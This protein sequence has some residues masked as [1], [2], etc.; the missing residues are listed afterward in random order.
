MENVNGWAS[1][2]RNLSALRP[3]MVNCVEVAAIF[4]YLLSLYPGKHRPE[5]QRL[6]ENQIRSLS[7]LRGIA[8]LGGEAPGKLH[9]PPVKKEQPQKLLVKAYHCCRRM[10]SDYASA[11]GQPEVGQVYE[12]LRQMA[13]EQCVL[14]AEVLGRM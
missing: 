4:Q 14:I 9:F 5:I 3:M 8:Q 12:A 2:S 10:E 13:L 7:Y 6:F 11:M 1:G